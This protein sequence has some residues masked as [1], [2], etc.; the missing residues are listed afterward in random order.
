M[1]GNAMTD[2]SSD[3]REP[4]P[5]PAK[6]I[7]GCFASCAFAVA[8]LAGLAVGNDPPEILTRAI[9]CLFGGY[10]LG[11]IAG[12]VFSFAIREHLREYIAEHPVPNS[13]VSLDE[14]VGALRVDKN[15]E[16][17]PNTPTIAAKR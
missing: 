13:D 15:A 17:K 14:L 9:V 16:S 6:V 5:P 7:A 1:S 12:E 4:V 11:L 8:I 2:P 10:V 3:L